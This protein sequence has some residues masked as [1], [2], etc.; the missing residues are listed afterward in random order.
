MALL[1]TGAVMH[2]IEE[3]QTQPNTTKKEQHPTATKKL[4]GHE[5][6]GERERPN[7]SEKR[8]ARLDLARLGSASLVVLAHCGQRARFLKK[9]TTPK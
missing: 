7:P 6:G 1:R 4:G 2:P 3:Q 5:Q 8:S 9:I